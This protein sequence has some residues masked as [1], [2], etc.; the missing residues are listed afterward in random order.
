MSTPRIPTAAAIPMMTTFVLAAACARTP[1]LERAEPGTDAGGGTSDGGGGRDVDTGADS[2]GGSD[3]GGFDA[4]TTDGG[5]IVI[6]A[7]VEPVD[8][9]ALRNSGDKYC[10]ALREC[11]PERF[12]QR[13]GSPDGCRDAITGQ[14][15]VYYEQGQFTAECIRVFTSALECTVNFGYCAEYENEYGEVVIGLQ[16]TQECAAVFEELEEL[17]GFYD[18]YDGYGGYGGD[19]GN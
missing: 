2:G 4:G 17:C 5:P 1:D 13:F 8:I 11:A 19:D 7:G 12:E 16:P 3:S 6:D 15:E 10:G 14:L 18:G 9:E